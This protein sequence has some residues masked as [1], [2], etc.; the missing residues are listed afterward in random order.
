MSELFVDLLFGIIYV[1]IPISILILWIYIPI[2]IA[3]KRNI[4]D[5]SIIKI[6]SICGLFFGITWFVALLMSVLKDSKC[7]GKTNMDLAGLKTLQELKEKGVLTDEEF[8]IEKEKIKN[9][10]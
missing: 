1:V 3:K 8:N 6:L 5:I 4:N 7:K 10:K 9:K 2:Y